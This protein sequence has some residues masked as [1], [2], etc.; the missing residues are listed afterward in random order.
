[1]RTTGSTWC[2]MSPMNSWPGWLPCE[3]E[4]GWPAN[5][6]TTS[7]TSW[8]SGLERRKRCPGSGHAMVSSWSRV[9]TPRSESRFRSSGRSIGR[10]G[11]S[12]RAGWSINGL[13]RSRWTVTRT[14][15]LSWNVRR[16]WSEMFRVS[17]WTTGSPE[18]FEL[19]SWPCVTGSTTVVTGVTCCSTVETGVAG[20]PP[21]VTGV[22]CCSAMVAGVASSSTV[23]TGVAGGSSVPGV[24]R[25]R[26]A[27]GSC[28]ISRPRVP[29]GTTGGT[30]P[31]VWMGRPS[32]SCHSEMT[33]RPG[34]RMST[35][36]ALSVS[37]AVVT[38]GVSVVTARVRSREVTS[39]VIARVAVV[40]GRCRG[41][42]PDLVQEL[43]G[44]TVT[45]RRAPSRGSTVHKDCPY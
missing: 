15:W 42:T 41:R 36:A 34:R 1:M 28:C 39:G 3:P 4:R 16:P 8:P 44:T 13:G 6:M 7:R 20:S 11:W 22:S 29:E 12:R 9:I 40:V 35:V 24:S 17:C 32:G 37:E 25:A 2:A 26:I 23:M 5:R 27:R 43:V 30:R 38:I 19:S 21:V 14:S 31:V 18:G 45:G 33:G 10:P